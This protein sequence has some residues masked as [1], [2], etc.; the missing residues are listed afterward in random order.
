[1]PSEVPPAPPAEAEIDILRDTPL[2]L[3]GYANEVRVWEC[4]Y[5]VLVLFLL[6]SH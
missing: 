2:R 6:V 3:L 5:V 4:Y 1:M